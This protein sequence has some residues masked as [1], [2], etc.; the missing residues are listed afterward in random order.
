MPRDRSF[1]RPSKRRILSTHGSTSFTGGATSTGPRWS[2]PTRMP[3]SSGPCFGAP[4]TRVS[5]RSRKGSS[6]DAPASRPSGDILLAV[7]KTDGPPI[8]LLR[9][10]ANPRFTPATQ[11]H[12]PSTLDG[13]FM[14]LVNQKLAEIALTRIGGADFE[15]F[16]R[17]FYSALTDIEFVPL[18]GFHDGGAD[19]YHGED[20][21]ERLVARRKSERKA[22]WRVLRRLKRKT[23]SSR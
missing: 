17:S 11:D 20:L 10:A 9:H 8:M 14:Q 13:G 18:G 21:F 22:A 16:F 12:A 1:A 3:G 15:H 19:A 7:D 6:A 4:S 5:L 23:N 2:S